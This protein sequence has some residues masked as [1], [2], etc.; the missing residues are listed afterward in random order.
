MKKLFIFGFMILMVTFLCVGCGDKNEDSILPSRG[1]WDN[2]VYTNDY[3]HLTFTMP[4]G[5]IYGSDE[6]IANL[7]GI[8]VDGLKE[9][10]N[11]SD[12]ILE[13]AVVY[14][15][16]CQDINTGTNVMVMYDNLA[17]YIGGTKTDVLQYMDLTKENLSK[18]NIN[19]IFGEYTEDVICGNKYNMMSVSVEDTD[20][21]YKQ[22]F[23]VRKLDDIMIVIVITCMGDDSIDVIMSNFK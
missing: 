12:K 23:Y 8:V 13:A 17:Y 7:M 14:D 3:V 9:D 18:T 22:N 2:N 15:M 6:E 19:Y 4:D 5:W 11:I 1:A 20:L 16:L 21:S 10:I